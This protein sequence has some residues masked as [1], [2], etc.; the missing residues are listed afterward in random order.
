MPQHVLQARHAAEISSTENIS[1][2][3][4]RTSST[5]L[6]QNGVADVAAEQSRH[7][8][9]K[10]AQVFRNEIESVRKVQLRELFHVD[11]TTDLEARLS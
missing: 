2:W 3:L 8:C 10:L 1:R 5:S 7:W 9:E 4:A 6:K 11:G